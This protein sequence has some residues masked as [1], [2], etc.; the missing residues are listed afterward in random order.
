MFYLDRAMDQGVAS[1]TYKLMK[2]ECLAHLNRLQEAQEIANSILATDKQNPDA[3]FVRG[4]CL[5]YDDKMDLAVNHFQLLLKLAPDH[6]KAK[7]TYKVKTA[8]GF[9]GRCVPRTFFKRFDRGNY[10]C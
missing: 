1:K 4:L 9:C 7:E 6:A 2:A 3:V 10:N 8:V 5:Y